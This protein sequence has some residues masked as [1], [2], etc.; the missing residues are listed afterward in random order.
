LNSH[1]RELPSPLKLKQ[2]SQPAVE[3]TIQSPLI[4]LNQQTIDPTIAQ[5]IKV[6][7][8]PSNSLQMSG[9]LN[10]Y[11]INWSDLKRD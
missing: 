10:Y 1:R 11:S 7:H 6:H 4:H 2:K 3:E 9:Q 8:G 5:P